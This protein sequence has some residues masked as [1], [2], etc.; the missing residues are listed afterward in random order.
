MSKYS[1]H[2][3]LQWI[4]DKSFFDGKKSNKGRK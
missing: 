2:E 1:L 4:G 3:K